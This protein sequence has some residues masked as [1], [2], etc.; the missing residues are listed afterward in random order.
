MLDRMNTVD[1]GVIYSLIHAILSL[2]GRN[3]TK[4]DGIWWNFDSI[5]K[6]NRICQEITSIF[7]WRHLHLCFKS[8]KF[9]F[10]VVFQQYQDCPFSLCEWNSTKI[11]EN[12]RNSQTKFRM[13]WMPWPCASFHCILSINIYLQQILYLFFI[14]CIFIRI[15]S[16]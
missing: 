6:R 4:W 14:A 9:S 15:N 1:L 13:N 16:E 2:F 12:L 8:G 7:M 11:N 10:Q 3:G 5:S